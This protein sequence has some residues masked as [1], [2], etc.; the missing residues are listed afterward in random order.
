VLAAKSVESENSVTAMG[1]W[2]ATSETNDANPASVGESST[3]L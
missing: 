1:D 2:V 3:V